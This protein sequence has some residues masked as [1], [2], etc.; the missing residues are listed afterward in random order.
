M[1]S[2][3]DFNY[4]SKAEAVA[5]L[6]PCLAIERWYD[7]IIEARPYSRYADLEVRAQQINDFT[8]QELKQAL[9]KHPRIGDKAKDTSKEASFSEREQA[10][11]GN[12]EAELL[13]EI[14]QG[15]MAYENR[16]NQV[17]LIRAKGR[18]Y[19]DILTE[20]KRRLSNTAQQE[21]Q[22]ISEQ[23]IQIA[24]L[25]LAMEITP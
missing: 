13:A 20:L 12:K 23:L 1:M 5:L 2:L 6:K 17:F 10:S 25:R 16:F 21:Q 8:P 9:A 22:E 4:C 14:Y 11:L 19:Q 15:N 18:S 24:L 7:G 3:Q